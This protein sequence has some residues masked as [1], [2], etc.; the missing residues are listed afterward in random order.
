[1]KLQKTDKKGLSEKEAKKRLERYGPNKLPEKR[2]LTALNI[3]V[4]QFKSPL[5]YILAIAAA[6]SFALGEITDGIIISAAVIINTFIGFF[7]EYR[8]DKSLKALKG[9][10]SLRA[11]IIRDGVEKEISSEEVVPGDIMVLDA[12]DKISADARL[13]ETHNFEVAEAALTGESLPIKKTTKIIPKKQILA[14]RKNMV[15]AGTLVFCGRARVVVV[16]IGDKTEV[17]K[18]AVMLRELPEEKTPLQ[19][20]ISKLGK[21]LTFIITAICLIIFIIGILQAKEFLEIFITSIAVAVAAIPEGLLIA[22]SIILILGMKKMLKEKAL[23]RKLVAAETLGSVSVICTDKTGTLTEGEMRVTKNNGRISSEILRAGLLCNDAVMRE[24]EDD[25]GEKQLIGDPMDK[26]LLLAGHDAGLSKKKLEKEMPRVDE[27]PFDSSIKY[28]ATIHQNDTKN[29]VYVKGAPEL[30]L[31][32]STLNNKEQKKYEARLNNLAAKGYRILGFGYRKVD[33]KQRFK[34]GDGL[35]KNLTFLGFVCFDDPLRPNTKET[36]GVARAA[37]I[38]PVIVTGDHKLTAVKIA[39]Q[40]GLSTKEHNVLT[41]EELEKMSDDELRAKIKNIDVF[42]RVEPRHKVRIVDAYQSQNQIV[43]MT[44]DGVNDA[45]A[46]KSADIGVALGYS[47]E[48]AKG[49][50]DMVILD[51]NFKT[52]V[53]AVERGR[54]IFENI[55]KVVLYL[56]S[57]SFSEIILILGSLALFLPLP[58]LPAQILWVNLIED[59]LPNIALAFDPGEKEVMSEKPRKKHAPILDKEMKILIFIIGILTDIILFGLFYYFWKTTGNLE[60]TRSIVFA[61]LAVNSLFYVWACRSFRFTIWHKNP[62][63][64]KFLIFSTVFGF[65]MLFIALYV[66]F[67]QNILRT[68]PLGFFE[69]SILTIF[70]I[71]NIFLIEIVKYVF[72]LRSKAK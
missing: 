3:L 68:V 28:M 8:A 14:E 12:G 2:S 16:E 29:I 15:Y 65:L 40:L 9:I 66:P 7:E 64:N 57:D 62:F 30:V 46:L 5:V 35:V 69:W 36:F 54:V 41:G 4:S 56:L 71:V 19:Q 44:G 43:A 63:A 67:F 48:V 42:A 33:K 22:V 25:N 6:V 58:I 31:S 72:I 45:P 13:I 17:G 55:K 37:G 39:E 70:G 27:V 24:V 11:K 50:S 52:I 49:A 60:Y 53:S 32:L 26:A 20:S 47:T 21:H 18:I 51:N 1:M 38:R 34:N 23:V 59:T 10:V 61:G